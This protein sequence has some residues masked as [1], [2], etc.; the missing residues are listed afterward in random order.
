[1]NTDPADAASGLRILSI[2]PDNGTNFLISFPTAPPPRRYG[3]LGYTLQ[4][5]DVLPAVWTNDVADTINGYGLVET[6][7]NTPAPGTNRFYRVRVG[8]GAT[9]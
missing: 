4:Y 6:F 9:R 1:M 8:R 3:A 7:T 5:S 2:V